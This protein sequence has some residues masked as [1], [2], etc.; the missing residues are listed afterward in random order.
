MRV[1]IAGIGVIA[2]GMDA[3]QSTTLQSTTGQSAKSVLQGLTAYSTEAELAAMIPSLLPA[4]ERRRTTPLIKLALCCAQQALQA[5]P[6]KAEN[7]ASVFASSC[8]DVK[9]VDLVMNALLMEG[10]PVSPTHFHNSVHNAPAGYCSIAIG[11]HAASTSLSAFDDS[12]SVGLL[13]AATQVIVEQQDVLLVAYDMPLPPALHPFRPLQAAFA[14]AFILTHEKAEHLDA[15]IELDIA[16]E[17]KLSQMNDSGLETLRTGNPAAR[18]LPLLQLL[19]TDTS[20]TV[21]LPYPHRQSLK[22]DLTLC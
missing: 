15:I 5:W 6:G 11:S 19:A 16:D 21:Y 3:W 22:L 12:F 13:E 2:P 18:S 10:K 14:T 1:G 8:G 9:I 7:L 20:G 4:N 17:T